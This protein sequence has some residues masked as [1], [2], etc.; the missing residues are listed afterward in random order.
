MNTPIL[1]Q[2]WTRPIKSAKLK[3]IPDDFVVTELLAIKHTGAGEHLWLYI[4][5]TNI[6]TTHIAQLLADWASIPLRDVGYSGLKDRHAVTHQWFSIRLPNKTAPK[7]DFVGFAAAHLNTNEAVQVEQS[8][9]HHR[10]LGR[11]THKQNHFSITLRDVQ[12]DQQSTNTLLEKIQ[13]GGVPN[14]FGQQRFGINQ[15]NISKTYEFFKKALSHNKPYRQN[16]KF[17]QRDGLLISTARSVLFN[18]MLSRRIS[19]GSWTTALDGDV[20]NLN[21]TGSIFIDDGSADID[22]RLKCCD[23]HP[24]APLYGN[25]T[26]RDS[27]QAYQLYGA[28]LNDEA[29]HLLC[30]GLEKVDAKLSY[31]PLRLMVQDLNWQWQNDSTLNLS[32]T[33]PRGTFAT[34]VLAAIVET[35]VE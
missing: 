7:G 12:A 29:Y 35:L 20:F 19:D 11:G 3:A 17:A 18:A 5:K 32:F 9:W 28:I 16:K 25:G 34:S 13:L 4:T 22:N 24:A 30:D 21:G 26:R 8:I 6:N 10:K 2:P 14:Y 27:Q 31:R 23:I 33:L 1:P 15:G